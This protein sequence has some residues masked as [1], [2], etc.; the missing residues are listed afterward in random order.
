LQTDPW[1][2]YCLQLKTYA[3]L[4]FK[5][6]GIMPTAS[7]QLVS[8][9]GGDKCDVEVSFDVTEYE[10]WLVRRLRELVD[11]TNREESEYKRRKRI[12]SKLKLPFEQARPGQEELIV[13]IEKG[14][15][16]G[17][18]ILVQA[19]TGLGKTMAVML[20]SLRDA[21][22]RGQKLIYVTP[23]NSVHIVAEDAIQ[24]LR[25][26]K[27]P[28]KSL[29]L[30]AKAK[31][32]K[33]TEMVCDANVCEYAR[34]YYTKVSEHQLVD[35]ASRQRHMNPQLFSELGE[36][37][38][39]CP[40]ELSID[41]IPR[42]DVVIC[43]YNHV[44]A[45]IS[46]AGRLTVPVHK[47]QEKP[48][49]VIDEAHNL[50]ARATG[51][52]SASVSTETLQATKKSLEETN[53]SAM[54]L[55]DSGIS[56]LKTIGDQQK[57]REAQVKLQLS[58]FTVI[59]TRIT[60]AMIDTLERNSEIDSV[61]P[62][63]E[64]SRTWTEI[65]N[66]IEYESEGQFFTCR[67]DGSNVTLKVTCCDASEYLK[68]QYGEFNSVIAFSATL[69]PF[70]YYSTLS[71]FDNE[72]TQVFEA[73]S[74][75]PA[76]NRKLLI[77]PQVSTRYKDREANYCKIA[78][79][80]SRIVKVKQANYIVFFP[81]FEF[82]EQISARVDAQTYT[83][84]VQKRGMSINEVNAVLDTLKSQTS[85]LLFAVQGGIF[86]EGVDFAGDMASG[87]IIVGPGLPT[88]DLEREL[89]REYYE[90][91][92]G[93]GFE[94]AYAYPAMTKVIQ[95]AGRVIRSETDRSLIVLLDRRFLEESYARAMPSDWY[96]D[97][98]GELVST[99]ILKD[100]ETFWHKAHPEV[101]I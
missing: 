97:A 60:K 82:L 42:A 5:Q 99:S 17:D 3:Y 23:K 41:C 15:L 46:L 49:L 39:V 55:A 1:H 56:L 87:A 40:F 58:D 52:F 92:Y 7:L 32:C 37:Y 67:R 59:N 81:S 74:P 12:A 43:D 91:T 85:C 64:L 76:E 26:K 70:D 65:C 73:S 77:I 6:T 53:R 19:P 27:V 16:K 61:K 28:I 98:P 62:I 36:Q 33:L 96:T 78:D 95:S 72:S 31:M 83:M 71:G 90:R 101:A 20:P 51:Y 29:T 2:P 18:P 25:A 57:S 48:N 11:E 93:S 47:Q 88:F 50:H 10:N 86:A 13:Q 34:D 4:H 66:A 68:K 79:A 94:Y 75:F 100:I 84:I 45:P 63:V 14:I 89:L 24:R 54:T 22:E 21:M 8:M 69:K 30:T 38:K 9:F 80:I 44:F 35:K